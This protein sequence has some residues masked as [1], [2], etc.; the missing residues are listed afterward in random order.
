MMQIF[1]FELVRSNRLFS[2]TLPKSEYVDSTRE[3][4]RERGIWQRRFWEHL[5]RD[6]IDY[7]NH[8]NYIHINPVKHGYTKR[9]VDWSHS[10]IH[11]FIERGIVDENWATSL[12]DGEYG[13]N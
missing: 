7:A 9:A 11:R 4:K 6:D 13:D 5:I 3:A 1:Q 2:R 12:I 10:S 8:V